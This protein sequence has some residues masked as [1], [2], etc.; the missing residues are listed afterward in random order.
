LLHEL[1]S[2]VII[3]RADKQRANRSQGVEHLHSKTNMRPTG[4][5]SAKTKF[6]H[7]HV[8]QWVRF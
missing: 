5:K 2:I 7:G 6:H 1:A 8:L 3:R 4:G